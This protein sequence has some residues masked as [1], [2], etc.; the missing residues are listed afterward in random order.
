MKIKQEI[1]RIKKIYKIEDLK[2]YCLFDNEEYRYVDFEKLF[3]IWNVKQGDTEYLLK[4]V[5]ELQKVKLSNGTLSWDNLTIK[6]LGENNKEKEYPYEIDPI[7]LYEHSQFDQE[8]L[9]DNLGVL[10]RS[11][12]KKAGLTQKQL[13]KKS[14]ISI[15][16]ISKLENK[17]ASIELLI[18][19]DILKNG[20]G[21]R[22][23]IN[24]D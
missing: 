10:I 12:R 9:V 11:E 2:I 15:D 1:V 21:K 24:I 8:K 23:K 7:V 6:L 13:A 17:K 18:Y 19:R 14:G 4:N 22:L 16:Y 5:Q 20:F 3:Q